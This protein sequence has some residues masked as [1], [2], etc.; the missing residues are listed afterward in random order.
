MSFFQFW[1]AF[2][3]VLASVCYDGR[4]GDDSDVDTSKNVAHK[5]SDTF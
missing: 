1:R 5:L 4:N 3:C 2:N